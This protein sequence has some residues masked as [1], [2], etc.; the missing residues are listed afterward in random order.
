MMA[1]SN[2][3]EEGTSDKD[4]TRR[5]CSLDDVTNTGAS[6]TLQAH[7]FGSGGNSWNN[8]RHNLTFDEF[9]A[10]IRAIQREVLMTEYLEY[11]R[12]LE[13]ISERDF[14][15]LLL[16]YTDLTEEVSKL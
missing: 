5:F 2:K 4:E 3:N 6:T 7:F 12:G 1:S 15:A 14:A 11:S 10:F 9:S 13:K 8:T 16:R